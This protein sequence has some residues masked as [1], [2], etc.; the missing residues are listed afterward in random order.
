MSEGFLYLKIQLEKAT[1]KASDKK[2]RIRTS[3]GI[4]SE[5]GR[6]RNDETKTES[7]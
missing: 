6:F 3:N 4:F 7:Q 5:D 1:A 2:P